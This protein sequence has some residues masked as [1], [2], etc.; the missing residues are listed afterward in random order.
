MGLRAVLKTS[1]AVSANY[2]RNAKIGIASRVCK[3]ESDI[4]YSASGVLR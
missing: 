4:F 2:V 3:G 1:C